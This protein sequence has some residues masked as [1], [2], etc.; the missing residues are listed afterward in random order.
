MNGPV[1]KHTPN[2][3]EW[4][5]VGPPFLQC[6]IVSFTQIIDYFWNNQCRNSE[7]INPDIPHNTKLHPDLRV[8]LAQQA[9]LGRGLPVLVGHSGELHNSWLVRILW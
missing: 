7:I 2:L 8:V 5:P 6:F 4:Y 9:V 1:F 3:G